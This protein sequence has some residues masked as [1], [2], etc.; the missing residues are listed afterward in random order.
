MF[1]ALKSYPKDA[2][3]EFC[4]WNDALNN[5]SLFDPSLFDTETG[6]EISSFAPNVANPVVFHLYGHTGVAESLVLTEDDYLQFLVETSKAN[7]RIPARIQKAFTLTSLLFLG[8][9]LTDLEFRV[10]LR[11]L[12]G[13]LRI[14]IAGSHVSAQVIHVGDEPQTDKQI[15]QLAKTREYLSSYC[16]AFKITTC[17]EL[18]RT[19]SSSSSNSAG[20]R[21]Q[22]K[23][24]RNPN[25]TSGP[26]RSNGKTRRFFSDEG[27][28][29]MSYSPLSS[30][31]W[32]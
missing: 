20:M 5:P 3:L 28:K 9:R 27:A 4:R 30:R 2:R 1:A 23:C 16:Q 10:L 14:S 26:A 19:T 11:S 7:L 15:A 18:Q 24:P 12:A 6:S 22:H 31:I 29:A 21:F 8:Y 32:K 25:P 13:S 17:W